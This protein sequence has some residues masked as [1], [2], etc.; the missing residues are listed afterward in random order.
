M[1]LEEVLPALK[2]KK[3]IRRTCWINCLFLINYANQIYFL[4]N[5]DVNLGQLNNIGANGC[6]Y[7]L[8]SDD[9]LAD[10]WEIVE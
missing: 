4:N 5:P 8:K 9:I 6:G 1:K 2:S 3:L 7:R 10:D